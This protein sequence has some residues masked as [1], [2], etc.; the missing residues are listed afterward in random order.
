MLQPQCVVWQEMSCAGCCGRDIST[1]IADY[2]CAMGAVANRHKMLD[3]CHKE[4]RIVTYELFSL[5]ADLTPVGKAAVV[6]KRR[7][8]MQQQAACR[9]V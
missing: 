1:G 9:G 4:T 3:I 8:A 6:G 7:L 2:L 5:G